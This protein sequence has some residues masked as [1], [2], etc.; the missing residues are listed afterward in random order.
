[1]AEIKERMLPVVIS[2]TQVAANQR[3]KQGQLPVEKMFNTRNHGHRQGLGPGPIH[4]AGQRHGVVNLTMNHQG[5]VV[6]RR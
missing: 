1:M 2:S 3:S 6:Q 5:F 4:H